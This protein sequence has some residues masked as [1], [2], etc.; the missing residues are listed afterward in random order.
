MPDP[1]KEQ[2]IRFLPASEVDRNHVVWRRTLEFQKAQDV[3]YGPCS[4][5]STLGSRKALA[6]MEYGELVQ[7]SVRRM[8][9]S[10]N[11]S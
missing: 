2:D 4:F 9:A 7:H 1:T 11:S 10:A 5:G 3:L 8:L 6:S